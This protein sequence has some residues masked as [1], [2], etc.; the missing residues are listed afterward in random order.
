MTLATMAQ[1][2]VNGRMSVGTTSRFVTHGKTFDVKKIG[3]DTYSMGCEG[4]QRRRYGTLREIRQ[5]VAHAIETGTLPERKGN[6]F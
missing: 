6:G 5:D 4:V 3:I 1:S 2:Y